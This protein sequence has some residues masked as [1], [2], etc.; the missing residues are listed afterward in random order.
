MVRLERLMYEKVVNNS[1][2]GRARKIIAPKTWFGDTQEK[3][4]P[5]VWPFSNVIKGLIAPL[6]D[7]YLSFEYKTLYRESKVHGLPFETHMM[8]DELFWRRE[9]LQEHV[10]REN[11]NP[12]VLIEHDI[13]RQRYWKIVKFIPGY[14]S[15]E[16]IVQETHSKAIIE[17][18][19]LT[20]AFRSIRNEY[21]KEMT[22]NV[23][24]WRSRRY[25]LDILIF[26]N[27]IDR[28]TWNRMFYN[29][30][31]YVQEKEDAETQGKYEKRLINYSDPKNQKNFISWMEN[32]IEMFPGYYTVE[33]AAFDYDT[34][35][36]SQ[37]ALNNHLKPSSELSQEQINEIKEKALSKS[38]KYGVY[39]DVEKGILKQ[40]YGEEEILENKNTVGVKMPEKFAGLKYRAWM[41]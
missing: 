32:Q 39:A 10:K 37:D 5:V 31:Y 28:D 14:E 40:Q 36:K 15:P 38:K 23:Y 13:M 11:V 41:A 7:K 26:H 29:E 34:Y 4:S 24:Q 27:L 9:E 21:H 2:F 1:L 18:K 19:D 35:F 20:E 16:E 30:A 25:I 8:M 3:H 33:G 6:K 12:W 22:P 17:N